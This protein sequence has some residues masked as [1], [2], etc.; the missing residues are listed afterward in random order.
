M[1]DGEVKYIPKEYPPYYSVRRACTYLG[2]QFDVPVYPW[3]ALEPFWESIAMGISKILLYNKLSK[4]CYCDHHVWRQNRQDIE[5]LR[6]ADLMSRDRGVSWAIRRFNKQV[7]LK[8]GSWLDPFYGQT[9]NFRDKL[10]QFGQ[11]ICN[12]MTFLRQTGYILLHEV[13]LG[14][15][16]LRPYWR[17]PLERTLLN[18][19]LEET[20]KFW[21]EF[22][23]KHNRDPPLRAIAKH[24]GIPRYTLIESELTRRGLYEMYRFWRRHDKV[25][26]FK[27]EKEFRL[28]SEEEKERIAEGI[29]RRVS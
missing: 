4:K 29:V 17:P 9:L 1:T 8:W 12:A 27:P 20:F 26:L 18:T 14:T 3:E 10:V 5:A 2:R 19:W 28:V 7:P 23:E 24:W 21:Y 16:I 22:E 13:P 6:L 11:F 25:K 15:S